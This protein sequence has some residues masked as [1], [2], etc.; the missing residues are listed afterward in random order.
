MGRPFTASVEGLEQIL[1]DSLYRRLS[2]DLSAIDAILA[3]ELPDA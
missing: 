2:E 1:L 3:E